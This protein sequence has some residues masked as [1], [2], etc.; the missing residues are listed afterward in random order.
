VRVWVRASGVDVD[1]S[2]RVVIDSGC[3]DGC[4][5]LLVGPYDGKDLALSPGTYVLR[6]D[7]V[8]TNCQVTNQNPARVTVERYTPGAV[9]FTIACVTY[10]DPAFARVSVAVTG[11]DLD[12]SFS[13]N[14]GRA[15]CTGLVL[16]PTAP[17]LVRFLPG[18]VPFLLS[19]VTSNCT[20]D[21]TNPRLVTAGPGQT[22]DVAFR[23]T[24]TKRPTI[25]AIVQ[26]S[27][28]SL[29][30]DYSLERCYS[31]G[32]GLQRCSSESL[33][34]NDTTTFVRE[35]GGTYVLS[36]RGVARN[37]TVGGGTARRIDPGTTSAVVTF[38][39]T[40]VRGTLVRVTLAL[41]GAGPDTRARIVNERS[42]VSDGYYGTYCDEGWLANGLQATF[43]VSPGPQSF[44]LLNLPAFCTL[45]SANPLTFDAVDGAT[46]EIRIEGTCPQ[47]TQVEVRVTAFGASV[48]GSF[49]VI[50]ERSCIGD[51]YYGTSCF[52]QLVQ[53]GES[54]RFT[55]T[56]GPQSFRLVDVAPNCALRSP[57]PATFDSPPGVTTA[58]AFNVECS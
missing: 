56:A 25:T 2:L 54:V 51:P 7:G 29:D 18:T 27:G 30:E 37:C 41:A 4:A 46:I 20:V 35:D 10:P 36:L 48:D 24:C 1:D 42:C 19:D 23:L 52:G 50:D 44:R 21:G 11:E 49:E 55:V 8:A 31:D 12:Q 58:V 13:V 26:T 22:V 39:V 15:D 6:L 45:S 34:G 16:S 32:T 33:A 28:T 43:S 3:A 47:A 40:C 17:R 53:S 5:P 57:N 14:C 9:T 38:P